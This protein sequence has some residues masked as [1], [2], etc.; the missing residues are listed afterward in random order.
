MLTLVFTMKHQSSP[1]IALVL[2]GGG[3]RGAYQAGFL[4][5]LA[6]ILPDKKLPFPILTGV[7]VG[8]INAA[9]LACYAHDFPQGTQK[10]WDMWANLKPEGVFIPKQGALLKNGVHLLSQWVFGTRQKSGLFTTLLD[11]KPLRDLLASQLDFNAI[12]QHIKN[13]DL[14]GV[15]F[16]ATNYTKRNSVSF[17]D[18]AEHL[19][20]WHKRERIGRRMHLSVE[21]VV[22]STALPLLFEPVS[23]EHCFYGDGST[24]LTAPLSPAIHLG[25]E[26][27]IAIT[28]HHHRED[29][30]TSRGSGSLFGSIMATL[31]RSVFNDLLDTDLERLETINQLLGSHEKHLKMRHIQALELKP[32]KDLGQ[33]VAKCDL[34]SQNSF[35]R[36]VKRIGATKGGD[37]ALISYL[38]FD[39]SYTVPLLELG[40]KDAISSQALYD[41]FRSA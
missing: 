40:Y 41:K 11:N 38:S 26:K 18:G 22:A 33:L 9:Y 23:L 31:L 37:H 28:M 1:K 19:P 12:R 36:L 6:E 13:G 30:P 39:K 5:G 2:A 32:S 20:S 17:F 24:T 34:S 25:A 29:Q 7:S 4:R 35:L 14:Q 15:C 8:A 10:L 16:T 21:H 3:A 27:I